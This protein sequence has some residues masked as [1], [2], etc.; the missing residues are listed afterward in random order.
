MKN[1]RTKISAQKTKLRKLR[2]QSFKHQNFIGQD[3]SYRDIRGINF[4]NAVL[5]NANFSYAKAGQSV[6]CIVSLLLC[7]LLVTILTGGVA[8]FIGVFAGGSIFFEDTPYRLVFG[9]FVLAV[10]ACLIGLLLW[11][12]LDLIFICSTSLVILIATLSLILVASAEITFSIL[13]LTFLMVALL[14]NAVV[15]AIALGSIWIT[16]KKRIILLPGIALLS[17]AL[18]VVIFFEGFT[19]QSLP[20]FFLLPFYVVIIGVTTINILLCIYLA[21][22]A[23]RLDA[24]YALI[25]RFIVNITSVGGTC[26]KGAD[27]SG[28]D[29]TQAV[30]SKADFRETNLNR[31]CW[32]GAKS[33]NQARID[34]TYLENNQ[35]RK[36]V[37]TLNAQ[38]E[39][40]D[41]LN[42]RHLALK[43]ANL[44][45]SSFVGAD[46]SEADLRSANLAGAK[47]VKT[48]LYQAN[49]SDACL[50][51]AYIQNWGIS[52][53]TVLANISCQYV[54]MRL[55]TQ[56][57]PDP[58]RK[59][60][61]RSETFQSG[62]FEDFITPI[63]KTLDLYSQQHIDP[64]KMASSFK[65]LDFYHHDGIDPTAAAIALQ[66]LAE[67]NPAAGLQVVAL[68]GRGDEKIR[69]QATVAGSFDRSKLNRRYFEKYRQA[70]AL[71]YT[72]QQ[73][74]I[75]VLAAKDKQIQNI[76]SMLKSAIKAGESY[77]KINE[78]KY[79][80][81]ILVFSAN[82]HNTNQHQLA[83]EV[84][85]IKEG[86][87]RARKRD[88]F[89]IIS[90]WAV[91]PADLR[92]AL[93]D[94]EPHIVHFS[95][96]GTD[97]EGL[98][99]EN[100]LGQIH[101]VKTAALSNLFEIFKDK[102][103]CVVL[104]ACYSNAQAEA[105]CQH[106]HYVIG[107]DQGTSGDAAVHFAVGFYDAL[108]AGRTIEDA[109]KLGHSAIELQDI[110][111]SS[112]PV[113][114]KKG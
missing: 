7:L 78:G 93:L 60:D 109:F 33:I 79:T 85:E 114:K 8:G 59:P 88:R 71:P 10:F 3:F 87:Q 20:S 95:G 69:L 34:N 106:I 19:S 72:E 94:Y 1:D 35:I 80:Q 13:A 15:G 103:E 58:W 54:Y 90:K 5:K 14:L 92:R 17:S 23:L 22:R 30:L 41:A 51:G 49:L 42:L 55:P 110:S 81:K 43:D 45:N 16:A 57:D 67:E 105:I 4:T 48:Q 77:I 62:D 68:D 12:G 56:Q 108:G 39:I 104:N 99:F 76:E 31:T 36:L 21:Y 102:V 11:R 61:N 97:H 70:I 38:G 63:I 112:Q 96:Y 28:A 86:L 111:S 40:F 9:T 24:R 6:K 26:F 89:E 37:V 107:T 47:L 75:D 50:T 83:V 44:Q 25:Y 53:N 52:A 2:K 32:F 46:L 84:R 113:L 91:R 98:A 100:E 18:S 101:F 74:L 66:Q 64:R 29:F 65:S 27:L 82:P 73:T